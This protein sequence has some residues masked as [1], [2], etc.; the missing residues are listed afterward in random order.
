MTLDEVLDQILKDVKFSISWSSL[1]HQCYKLL[2]ED[3][4]S[5][6]PY[7]EV[8]DEDMDE[9]G[10]KFNESKNT[11]Y[12]KKQPKRKPPGPAKGQVGM[13]EVL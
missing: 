5:R 6:T 11:Y 12:I 3:F 8:I 1:Y 4:D 7:Y 13:E 10:F 2:G 9:R